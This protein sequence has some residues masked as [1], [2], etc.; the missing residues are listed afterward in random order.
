[1]ACYRD[2]FALFFFHL[3]SPTVKA[4]S[5]LLSFAPNKN[6]KF[7]ASSPYLS[8]WKMVE[9]VGVCLDESLQFVNKEGPFVYQRIR[10]TCITTNW[11]IK[12]AGS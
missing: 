11:I 10:P 2:S 7:A 3:T 12:E 1:M 6:S 4:A 5:V 9:G 8:E